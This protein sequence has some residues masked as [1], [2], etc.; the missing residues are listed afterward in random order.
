MAKDAEKTAEFEQKKV[1]TKEVATEIDKELKPAELKYSEMRGDSVPF[2]LSATQKDEDNLFENVERRVKKEQLDA[3]KYRAY[4]LALEKELND[5]IEA[6]KSKLAQEKR[7]EKIRLELESKVYQKKVAEREAIEEQEL[8][9]VQGE[10]DE[11]F[12]SPEFMNW[13]GLE[14]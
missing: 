2:N 3:Q 5:I 7:D 4:D 8:G 14:D 13:N 12:V 11:E 1:S 9:R 10:L 6:Q